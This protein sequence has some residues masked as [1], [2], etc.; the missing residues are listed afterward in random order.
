MGG[1][2]RG[3]RV[4]GKWAE[5]TGSKRLS[6]RTTKQK[7]TRGVC[8]RSTHRSVARGSRRVVSK[9]GAS[10]MTPPE[11]LRRI[12]RLWGDDALAQQPHGML[13]PGAPC[14]ATFAAVCRAAFKEFRGT[15]GNVGKEGP[16]PT[17]LP[18][19]FPS[20]LGEPGGAP[21]AVGRV[22]GEF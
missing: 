8:A 6:E 9:F 4:G 5:S 15:S 19:E 10:A 16:K 1:A 7:R 2:V 18:G 11:P 12:H 20:A 3:R 22:H 17:N 13:V 14:I 21:G